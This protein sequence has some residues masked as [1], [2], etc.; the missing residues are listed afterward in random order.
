MKINFVDSVHPVLSERLT[1]AGHT[2]E[3]L[4]EY[5]GD[6]LLA[7]LHDSEGLVVRS[8]LVI[9]EAV[10]NHAPKLRFIA[11]AGAGMENI[12]QAV[13]TARN[14]RLYNSPEGNRD[15]VA[16]H[17]LG[18]LLALMNHLP[19]A[20]REVRRGIWDRIA[21]SGNELCGGTVGIVG[22]GQMGTA[23]A[24][25]LNGFGVKV[26]AHDKYRKGFANAHVEE[27]TREELLERSDVVSLHLPLT[28]ETEH[29]AD[30]AFF[31]A[32]GRSA[33]FI[34]TARGPLVDT[35]ALLD[36]IDAGKVR[37]ACLDVLE[38]E[39]RSLRGLQ[40]SA[41]NPVQ[42]RLYACD[43]V[44]LSPHVA[45]ITAES[46]FKLANVLADKILRDIADGRL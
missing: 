11:R 25:R 45:G 1:V 12:H 36:A 28:P 42:Q 18:M 33:W 32:L 34:N 15:S 40:G 44:L 23:F 41:P 26:L 5:D 46:Y 9:D 43:K 22:F 35:A 20:D 31:N 10:L 8:R 27:V 13:C 4:S 37:G 2:C 29:Y 17:A 30:A 19:K 7:Q 21:N 38:F 39:E 3:D 6:A 14:I 24:Q 16:E